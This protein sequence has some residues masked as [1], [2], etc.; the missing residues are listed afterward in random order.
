MATTFDLQAGSLTIEEYLNAQGITK[1]TIG[2]RNIYQRTYRRALSGMTKTKDLMADSLS[3][4]ASGKL[5]KKASPWKHQEDLCKS[6]R[7]CPI[8]LPHTHE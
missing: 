7:F 5:G 4:S 6:A 3:A 2:Y 8:K 1:A